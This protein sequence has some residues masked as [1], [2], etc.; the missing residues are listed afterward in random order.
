MASHCLLTGYVEKMAQ[1][2]QKQD[3]ERRPGEGDNTVMP[4]KSS[5]TTKASTSAVTDAAVKK[6]TGKTLAQ[7]KGVLQKAKGK[8]SHKEMV[9]LLKKAGI[10]DAE[11][12]SKVAQALEGSAGGGGS[13]DGFETSVQKTYPASADKVWELLMSAAGR[14]IWLGS[15]TEFHPEKGKTFETEKGIT[16]EILAVDE[17]KRMHFSFQAKGKK[18]ASRV[19]MTLTPN[20]GK[21]GVCFDHLELKNKKE[22]EEMRRRWQSALDRINAFYVVEKEK[23]RE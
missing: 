18:P 16:G 17:G 2:S 5:K 20:H 12:C 19:E 8:H 15:M 4:T 22:R 13:E 11:W 7:W 9:A 1:V 14:T 3:L 10:K 21:T 6:A 23:E